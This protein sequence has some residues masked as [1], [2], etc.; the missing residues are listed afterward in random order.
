MYNYFMLIGKVAN[1]KEDSIVIDTLEG[2]IEVNIIPILNALN[3]EVGQ[4][5]GVVGSIHPDGLYA[6]RIMLPE[7]KESGF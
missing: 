4:H 3:F 7:Y 2:C 5:I 1:V 6:K